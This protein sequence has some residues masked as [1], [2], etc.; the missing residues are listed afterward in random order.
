MSAFAEMVTIGRVVK[1]Q[2]RKGEL[3]TEPLTDRPDRFP[4]LKRAYVAGPAGE[5]REVRVS[6]CWPHKGRFVLKL[7]GV[8]SIDAAEVFRGLD[9]RIAPEELSPLPPGSYY[10]HELI[11][12][13]AVEESGRTVG[14][15]DGVW[16]T[17]A[18]A[19]LL[20]L[21]GEAGEK[22]LPLAGDFVKSVDREAGRVVVALPEAVEAR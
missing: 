6:S 22:L 18:G 12:L 8:D 4:T 15:V 5:A 17:G 13:L 11:G 16:E 2:G 7:E 3:L 21:H 19:P 10:H 9:V 20:V 1:P 14:R